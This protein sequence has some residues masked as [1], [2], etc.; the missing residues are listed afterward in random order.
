M[1]TIYRT[2]VSRMGLVSFVDINIF[3]W[4]IILFSF[5]IFSIFFHPQRKLKSFVQKYSFKFQALTYW[6]KTV[7]LNLYF[8]AASYFGGKVFFLLF[9]AH[10]WKRKS[11]HIKQIKNKKRNKM[12]EVRIVFFCFFFQFFKI[13]FVVLTCYT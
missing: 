3:L 13:L 5:F 8:I 10:V 2:R 12:Y 1:K 6:K 9:L 4:N 11:I 7:N